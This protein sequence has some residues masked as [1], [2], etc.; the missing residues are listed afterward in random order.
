MSRTALAGPIK[1][2]KSCGE[3]LFRKRYSTALED[4]AIF[5][6]RKFCNRS[7]MA[8]WM[9]GRIKNPVPRNFRRQSKKV[10]K[11]ACE[12]CGRTGTQLYVHHVDHNPTNNARSNL[13]T[14]CGACH[15]RCHGSNHTKTGEPN[16]PCK[17]CGK[18]SARLDFCS[19]HLTRYKRYGD[20]RLKKMKIGLHWVLSVCES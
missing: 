15:Q 18:Q 10:V 19:T 6:K 17:I 13:Q 7:C 14:L 11:D 2:C 4:M 5:I 20:P 8:A 12:K 3:Q 1:H 9:E 16:R